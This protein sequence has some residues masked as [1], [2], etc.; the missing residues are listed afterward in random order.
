MKKFFQYILNFWNEIIKNLKL[1]FLSGLLVLVPLG[2]TILILRFLYLFTVGRVTPYVYK[3]FPNYPQ[4]LVVPVSVFIL[5][6]FLYLIG[7]TS[8]LIVIRQFLSL[9]EKIIS[10]IPF[11]KSVYGATKKMTVGFIEQFASPKANA[12][13]ALVPFPHA[14]IYSMG[15][16]LGKVKI[17]DNEIKYRVFIPTVPNISI[18][19]LHFYS[20]DQIYKCQISMEEAIEY[21]VSAGAS[22]PENMKVEKFIK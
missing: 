14:E 10:K 20:K 11:I 3:W 1:I 9:M 17:S 19:V 13:I 8:N 15:I 2:L 18:G 12:T 21:I 16:V 22:M 5:L 4:Y 7:L 6:V